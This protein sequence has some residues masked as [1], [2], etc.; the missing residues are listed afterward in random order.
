MIRHFPP[1]PAAGPAVEDYLAELTARLPGPAQAHAGIVAELRSGLLDAT[2]AHRSAGL[3]PAQAAQ[4]AIR[5]FGDPAQVAAGFRA[6]IAASQARRTAIALLVT[7]PLVG[8][9][10][11]ATA[12]A[13]HLGIGLALPWH[14]AGL[15]PGLGVGIYLVVAAAGVTAWGAVLAIATTGR[16]TRWLPT[17]PRRAPTG[18]AVAGY[19]AVSADGLGLILLAAELAT[20]PGK[21][22]P[23]P[24]A[25]AAAASIA[26]MLLARRAARHCLVIRASLT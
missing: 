9:L 16:L 22:S 20:V 13:S 21:L 17:R 2:D 4:A 15:S 25:A 3:P 14:W 23:L 10:W 7:G 8:L 19:S 11:I 5:E 18:A 12:A 24:A 6:E 26:R 1:E